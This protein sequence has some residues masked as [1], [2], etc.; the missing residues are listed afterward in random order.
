MAGTRLG[1]LGRGIARVLTAIE[2]WMDRRRGQ[3]RVR[4]G[5][6][7]Q[8]ELQPYLGHG[9]PTELWLK[10]RVLEQ[11]GL[12]QAAVSDTRWR[13]LRNMV[14]RMAT[15]EIAEARVRARLVTEPLETTP[16]AGQTFEQE[17]V[18]DDEGYFDVRLRLPAPLPEPIAWQHVELELLA[19]YGP[20]H[21]R[22]EARGA[23]LAVHDAPFGII[24]D[25]DDT[26]V[27]T[28]VTE[29]G[30][31][32][33]IALT[34]NA[35]TRLPFDGVAELYQ[36]FRRGPDGRGAN[37]VFYVSNSPWNFHDMLVEFFDLQ[38]VPRGPLFLRDWS[39]T[40]VKGG[41]AI[42]KREVI[43]RLLET[44]PHMQ[45]VL[46]G[47]SGEHDPE[48]YAQVAH[49]H[50]ERVRVIYIREV[51]SQ[52]RHEEVLAIAA[53]L[54]PLGVEMVLADDTAVVA[55]HARTLGLIPADSQHP[56]S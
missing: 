29:L 2:L 55:A 43:R 47:D 22:A 30:K 17:V 8:P 24:S 46:I 13:N 7:R 41:G 3:R 23:I 9:T 36:A 10:G 15:D 44:Y 49:E 21:N 35:H 37:P 5:R 33:W 56:Q 31:M 51:T 26:V 45:F 34:S 18:T 53:E 25:L 39:P 40:T 32:L 11:R 12:L 6:L 27:R 42:H 20:D 14:R 52:E 54:R 48:I 19:P 50:P 28:G 38:G 1:R 16:L 4:R